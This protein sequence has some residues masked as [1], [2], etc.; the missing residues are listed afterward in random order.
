MNGIIVL[1]EN[2]PS[3][4]ASV[5]AAVLDPY[6]DESIIEELFNQELEVRCIVREIRQFGE[7]K[8]VSS[9]GSGCMILL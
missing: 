4:V 2:T 1:L 6:R 9:S 8:S 5:G 7:R 3:Y